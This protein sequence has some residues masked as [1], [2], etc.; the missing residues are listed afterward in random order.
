M[1]VTA[2]AD[3]DAITYTGAFVKVSVQLA[4]AKVAA[5]L[6][7]SST[8]NTL[9]YS[10]SLMPDSQAPS[11]DNSSATANATGNS[12]SVYSI[13]EKSFADNPLRFSS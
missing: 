12:T 4:T 11:F 13:N 1:L 6:F 7:S 5:N 8:T 10:T 2:V 9:N 3:A